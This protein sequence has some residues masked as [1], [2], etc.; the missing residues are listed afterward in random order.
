MSN[1]KKVEKFM[2]AYDQEVLTTPQLPTF[3]LA[4]LRTELI[5]EEFTELITAINKF[6]L[7]EIADALTDILYVTYGAGHAMGIDLDKCF[8]EV[9]TSNMSK[10]GKD[11]KPVKGPSGKVMKGENYKE[12]NLN[13]VLFGDNNE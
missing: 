13:K 11:G 8:N 10:M 9:H 7:V 4:E 2:K 5:K 1:F 12:P 6:D 3:E